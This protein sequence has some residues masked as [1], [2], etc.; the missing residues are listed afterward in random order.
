MFIFPIT[1]TRFTLSFDPFFSFLY[2]VLIVYLSYSYINP[3]T[4]VG[5]KVTDFSTSGLDGA[6]VI[7]HIKT[8]ESKLKG[9]KIN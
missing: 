8:L 9:L 1:V 6:L 5:G 3:Y 2:F 4:I 7:W